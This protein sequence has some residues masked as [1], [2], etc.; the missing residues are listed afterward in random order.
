MKDTD[1]IGSNHSGN[2]HIADLIAERLKRR[3]VVSGGLAAAAVGFLGGCFDGGDEIVGSTRSAHKKKNLLGFEEVP[4]STED[5][6]VVPPGY[7]WDVL[8]PWGTGL[9]AAS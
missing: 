5:T 3:D 1:D 2:P 7:T 6:I 9:F 8:I 4:P